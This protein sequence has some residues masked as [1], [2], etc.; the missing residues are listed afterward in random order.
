MSTASSQQPASLAP[1]QAAR[2]SSPVPWQRWLRRAE[3]QAERGEFS[4]AID[5]LEAAITAGAECYACCLQMA[6]LYR[7]LGQWQAALTIAE[8]AIGLD[9]TRIPAYEK[10]MTLALEAGDCER[11]IAASCALIK[12]APRHVPAHDTLGAAYIQMGD[13]DAAIRVTNTLIRLDPETPAHHFKKALLCQHKG[14]V[15]LAVQEFTDA[16][17]LDPCGP[18][19]EAARE[20]LETLDTFQ[21]NQIVTLAMED[22]VFRIKLERDPVEAAAE[23]GFYLSETGNQMLTELSQMALPDFPEP[24]RPILYN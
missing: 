6:D 16:I 23:R 24:C 11:A 20:A 7:A 4:E 2:G 14:E 12:I 1:T 8:Q 13:V 10:V 15:A 3:Q 21:L 18:H 19:A 5:S 22:T 9:P 17:L